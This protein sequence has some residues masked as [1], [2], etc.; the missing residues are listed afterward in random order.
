MERGI[1]ITLSG[2]PGGH[3]PFDPAYFAQHAVF[4][5]L[6]IKADQRITFCEEAEGSVICFSFLDY[7]VQDRQIKCVS[8]ED[9]IT[10]L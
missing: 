7:A 10:L 1:H 6:P 2:S 5:Y 8:E 9:E 4:M 3:R